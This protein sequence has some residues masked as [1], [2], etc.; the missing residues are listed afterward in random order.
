MTKSIPIMM[1]H[2]ANGTQMW[3]FFL[4]IDLTVSIRIYDGFGCQYIV[5]DIKAEVNFI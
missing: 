3:D 4:K 5:V 1:V 2:L